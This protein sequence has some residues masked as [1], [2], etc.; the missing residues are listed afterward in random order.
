MIEICK[1]IKQKRYSN[2]YLNV[3]LWDFTVAKHLK[4]TIKSNNYETNQ[5]RLEQLNN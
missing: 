2:E 3:T 4:L 5:K 1:L